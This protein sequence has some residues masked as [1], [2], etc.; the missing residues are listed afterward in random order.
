MGRGEGGL[1]RLL[2][3]V[4]VRLESSFEFCLAISKTK[5][6]GDIYFFSI[7]GREVGPNKT[8]EVVFLVNVPYV[9]INR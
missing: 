2:C 6:F 4:Y 1:S 7:Y 5:A 3:T 9:S 8:H